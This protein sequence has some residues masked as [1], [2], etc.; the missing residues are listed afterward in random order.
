MIT[1]EIRTAFSN[2]V[3]LTVAELSAEQARPGSAPVLL[4][5]AETL[6]GTDV[7]RNLMDATQRAFPAD[8]MWI[9][10]LWGS[11]LGNFFRRT[12]FYEDVHAGRQ[13]VST[14]ELL[15]KYHACLE[16][17][18]RE[19]RYLAPID[20]IDFGV[21]RLDLEGFSIRKFSVEEIDGLFENGRRKVFYPASIIQSKNLADYWCL[22]IT[23]RTARPSPDSPLDWDFSPSFQK[24]ISSFPKPIENALKRLVLFDWESIQTIGAPSSHSKSQWEPGKGWYR[25]YVPA[26]LS[27]TD[28]LFSYPGSSVAIPPIEEEPRYVGESGEEEIWVPS[29]LNMSEDERTELTTLVTRLNEL[30]P[31]LTSQK[32]WLFLDV[33]LGFIV[34]AFFSEGLEQLLWHIAVVESLLG[35]NKEG[36]TDLLA[37]RVACIT[38]KTRKERPAI[39]ET[40][41]E[42]YAFRS[43]LVHGNR[44]ILN[45]NKI[46]VS[47]LRKARQIARET[48]IWFLDWLDIVEK[49][50]ADD[51]CV[52]G[53]PERTDLLSVLDMNGGR[54]FRVNWLIDNLPN[55]FPNI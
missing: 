3:D 40:F 1:T 18:D 9:V 24:E 20:A 30:I 54:R 23:T 36:L 10:N 15:E 27:M 14:E 52:S 29:Y 28:D 4:E 55:Q 33:A 43:N 11:E 25:F 2:Y 45:Q 32:K 5:K 46:Y 39:M 35:E 12:G 50:F 22:D 19:V 31:R 13:F 34:K 48:L 53:L 16:R 38:G 41:E 47:H 17:T 6:E 7:F 8:G 51:P 42:L 37:R 44:E 26:V 49:E 21:A